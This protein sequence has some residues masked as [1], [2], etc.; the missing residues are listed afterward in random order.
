MKTG[1]FTYIPLE[2]ENFGVKKNILDFARKQN[3]PEDPLGIFT[4][5][6]IYINAI[7]YISAHLTTH[8]HHIMHIIMF[9]STNGRIYPKKQD[10]VMNKPLESLIKMLRVFEFPSKSTF[11]S[12]LI[13]FKDYR[14]KY[15]HRLM[16]LTEKDLSDPNKNIDTELN[17]LCELSEEIIEDYDSIKVGIINTWEDYKR[18]FL[19]QPEE[20]IPNQVKP[21]AK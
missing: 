12:K 9:R 16:S 17:K 3:N 15:V 6:L 8:I 2:H 14:N 21:I 5:V 7:D 11:I 10:H 1:I 4:R 19:P 18:P 13:Q 20:N